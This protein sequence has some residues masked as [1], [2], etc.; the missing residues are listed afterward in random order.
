VVSPHLDDAV[1]GCGDHIAAHPGAF[2]LTIFAG[3][4]RLDGPATDWD[5]AAGFSGGAAAMAARRCEDREALARLGARPIWLD[6]LDGQYGRSP[7]PRAI[8]PRLRNVIACH[9]PARVVVPL[10]L[11][12][13]D[14]RVAHTACR[15]LIS[16]YPQLEWCAYADAIYRRFED[17]GLM[18]RLAELEAV[19]LRPRALRRIRAAS[20]RKRASI[21]CY[22]SQLRALASPGRPGWMDA[23]RPEWLWTLQPW[24]GERPGVVC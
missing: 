13:R 19:G 9:R 8:V 5:A 14:H 23:L 21:A 15:A 1:L 20:P 12:H 7:R 10:G 11:W 2:V 24:S 17:S 3:A 4:P 16:L 18:T 6:F 22:R